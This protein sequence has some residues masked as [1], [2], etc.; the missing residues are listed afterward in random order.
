MKLIAT[1]A[2]SA[3]VALPVFAQE[4][5]SLRVLMIG[6]SYSRSV[7]QELPAIAKADPSVKLVIR[8]ATIGGCTL[9]RHLNEFE[10]SAAKPDHRPYTVNLPIPGRKD[11]KASLQECLKDGQ[12][13]IV[14]IQ[15]AS[16]LSWDIT[17][18]DDAA[19]L[20]EIVRKFQPKAEII[21]HMTWS[22]R[23]DDPRI[24]P[25]GKFNL[26]QAQMQ[27]KII[28]CYRELA[29]RHR[30]RIIPVGIAVKLFRERVPQPFTAADVPKTPV[31]YEYPNLPPVRN[32][33]VGGSRWIRHRTTKER[34]LKTDHI[35][36]NARG[37]YLQGC[38]WYM[39][40]FGKTAKDVK[41]VSPRITP[42][43]ARFLA[44][45]AEVA[46]QTWKP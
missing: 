13:D 5:K 32:D 8:G 35:H 43:D 4:A 27:E 30:I 7:L 25:G 44:Q 19:R 2:L 3:I 41:Y 11:N 45:C 29:R 46:V 1:I 23:A 9:Q 33:V 24:L 21:G 18:F 38:V 36:F 26:T 15:Q 10:T 22:Y 31:K 20:I 6:N 42:E 14:T 28:A 17:T 37:E 16:P 40:L 39:F 34:V 12:Y